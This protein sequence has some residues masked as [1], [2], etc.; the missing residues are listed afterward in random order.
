MRSVIFKD[1]INDQ[2]NITDFRY[3]L[4]QT[5]SFLRLDIGY[6]NDL[7]DTY[8]RQKSTDDYYFSDKSFFIQK[9]DLSRN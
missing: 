6:D 5:G 9:V 4:I 2:L 7:D 3:S 8:F 1:Y